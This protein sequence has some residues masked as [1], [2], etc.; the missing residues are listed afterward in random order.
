[1]KKLALALV[2]AAACGGGGS[3]KPDTTP[4]DT[5]T[6]TA[7]AAVE[8]EL[9]EIKLIDVNKNK[10]LLVHAD[11]TIELEGQKPAKVTKDGKIVKI[12]TGEVGFT[13]NGDGTINGPDGK[14]LEVTLSADGIV[15]NGD[16]K[17]TVDADGKLLGGN[18]N[19]PQMKI[20]GATTL[21]LKRTALFVLIALTSPMPEE[22]K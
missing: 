11:G 9:G 7:S 12:D 16:K 2:L 18:P 22:K 10:A 5:K 15:S 17:I 21:G 8:L 6:V 19:A 13:L 1:M 14:P 4:T 3:K 20:E